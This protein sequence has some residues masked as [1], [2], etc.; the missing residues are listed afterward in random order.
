MKSY[1]DLEIYKLSYDLALKVHRLSLKLP[2]HELY[3]EGGQLRRSSKGIPA[4]IVE[5]YGRGKYKAEFNRFLVYAQASCDETILHLNFVK[6][7]YTELANE[8]Q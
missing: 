3:E 4:C 5:G 7:L 1:T 6:D 2:Q 8:A